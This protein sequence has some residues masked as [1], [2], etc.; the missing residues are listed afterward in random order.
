MNVNKLYAQCFYHPDIQ[1]RR[2]A[3]Y[4]FNIVKITKQTIYEMQKLRM[5]KSGG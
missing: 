2:I 3:L 5:G 1:S 4:S